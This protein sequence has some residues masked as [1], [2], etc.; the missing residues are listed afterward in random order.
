MTNG[1]ALKGDLVYD[2]TTSR[3]F[4]Y[5]FSAIGIKFFDQPIWILEDK[6][7]ASD[8]EIAEAEE[9]LTKKAAEIISEVEDAPDV[10]VKIIQLPKP[11]MFVLS[12]VCERFESEIH[13]FSN[14]DLEEVLSYGIMVESK[15]MTPFRF[16]S[17]IGFF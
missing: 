6:T 7:N 15:N 14:S 4:I 2:D 1:L 5:L 12:K 3:N 9:V 10:S 17:Y 8:E 16:Y 13:S 11:T